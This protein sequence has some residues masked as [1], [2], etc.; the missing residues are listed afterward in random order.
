M[1]GVLVAAWLV[2]ASPPQHVI[3]QANVLSAEAEA[4]LE[5]QLAAFE[6]E[7]RMEIDVATFPDQGGV[8]TSIHARGIANDW[9][10]GSRVG[11]RGALIAFYP[12]EREVRIEIADA[13]PAVS[14]AE[15]AGV[16]D[17]FM[18]PAFQEAR[19]ADGLAAGAYELT[20]LLRIRPA[21]TPRPTVAAT[22]PSREL[23]PKAFQAVVFGVAVVLSVVLRRIG[24]VSLVGY[25]RRWG[26]HHGWSA[27]G[28]PSGSSRSSWSGSSPSRSTWS[29]SS[30]SGRPSGGFSG[31][32]ASG[33][34]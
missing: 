9:R 4:D 1:T 21:A 13:M 5:R 2:L 6:A 20:R 32:G 23:S 25:R 12:S 8:P 18:V 14:D 16:I 7:A 29:S 30:S 17:R 31:R 24:G 26:A 28:G 33:K 22:R 15:I 10:V 3:D 27:S 34:W 19:Y 11:D